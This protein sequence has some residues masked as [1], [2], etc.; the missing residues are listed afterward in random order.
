MLC[1]KYITKHGSLQINLI[2]FFSS[3]IKYVITVNNSFCNHFKSF[4]RAILVSFAYDLRYVP[5]DE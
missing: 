4:F 1:I 5:K 3:D 2:I